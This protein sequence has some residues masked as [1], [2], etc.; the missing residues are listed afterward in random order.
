VQEILSALATLSPKQ[1]AAVLLH[2]QEGF[3][4][5]EVAKLL[6]MSPPRS[7]STCSVAATTCARS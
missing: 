2:D 3:T 4:S 7:A 1:R 5:P 6:G